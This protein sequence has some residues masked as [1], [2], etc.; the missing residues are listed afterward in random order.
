MSIFIVVIVDCR[1]LAE[2]IFLIWNL[3]FVSSGSPYWKGS[4]SGC[5]AGPSGLW[6]PR[7]LWFRLRSGG[8]SGSDVAVLFVC[9]GFT[10]DSWTT[11]TESGSSL[12][13]RLSECGLISV[14]WLF[15]VLW[16]VDGSLPRLWCSISEWSPS[17][18]DS[19]VLVA[20]RHLTCTP[21]SPGKKPVWFFF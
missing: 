3:T 10:D 20:R 19:R 12:C 14:I 8:E 17:L 1:L 6:S 2:I 21:H 4:G 15:A 5:P 11:S 13:P 9:P 18:T 7:P 16:L